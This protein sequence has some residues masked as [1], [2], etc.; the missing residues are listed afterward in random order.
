MSPLMLGRVNLVNICRKMRI[1][2]RPY[3]NELSRMIAPY[4]GHEMKSSG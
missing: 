3:N 1:L 4:G 2:P